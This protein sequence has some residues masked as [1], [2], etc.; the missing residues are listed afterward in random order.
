[1]YYHK[2]AAQQRGFLLRSQ[3][4]EQD[5]REARETGFIVEGDPPHSEHIFY[6][7]FNRSPY[8]DDYYWLWLI[9][10]PTIPPKQRYP[11][12][13]LTGGIALELQNAGWDNPHDP[14]FIVVPPEFEPYLNTE[15]YDDDTF[16]IN[17]NIQLTDWSM[18]SKIPVAPIMPALQKYLATTID[19]LESIADAISGAH[20]RG[21]SWEELADVLEIYAERWTN[22]ETRK[23]PQT[24]QGVL[25]LI[26]EHIYAS[27]N[28]DDDEEDDY[29]YDEDDDW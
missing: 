9:A 23:I 18:V 17:N 21:F 2:L 19:D 26:K 6:T 29:D 11:M 28:S 4:T 10:L 5:I 12:P 25:D 16:I 8:F 14:V 15:Y 1:M 13:Y 3:L 20:Y 27:L 22:D 24:G 7:K